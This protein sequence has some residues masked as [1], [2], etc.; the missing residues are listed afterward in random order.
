MKRKEDHVELNVWHVWH[1]HCLRLWWRSS[2]R[3]RHGD[4]TRSSFEQCLFPYIPRPI[5]IILTCAMADYSLHFADHGGCQTGVFRLIEL[6]KELIAIAE[7]IIEQRYSSYALSLHSILWTLQSLTI[8]GGVDEDAVLCTTDRTYSVRA[9]TLSNTYFVL[10]P[11]QDEADCAVIRGSAQQILE[12]APSISKLHKLN[13]LLR[14]R[15]YE[16]F[17]DEEEGN[18][19]NQ[20]YVSYLQTFNNNTYIVVKSLTESGDH[21]S[22]CTSKWQGVWGRSTGKTYPHPEW[23]TPTYHTVIPQFGPRTDLKHYGC[24]FA[25]PRCCTRGRYHRDPRKW[26]RYFFWGYSA[27][28]VLVRQDY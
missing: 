1:W 12:L 22:I 14:G 11:S 28:D 18:R 7:G 10:A 16:G 15:E 17:D 21:Q 5:V 3:P 27:S 24:M 23:R 20:S 6:P 8:R 19:N 9:V 4:A 26:S 25:T 13:G 2:R